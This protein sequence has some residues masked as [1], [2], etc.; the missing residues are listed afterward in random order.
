MDDTWFLSISAVEPT[1]IKLDSECNCNGV[2]ATTCVRAGSCLPQFA[3]F[4]GNSWGECEDD[5][6]GTGEGQLGC[7][8][9]EMFRNCADVAIVTNTAG[10][11]PIPE[12]RKQVDNI[13]I[14]NMQLPKDGFELV[15][16]ED[17]VDDNM[18]D[19]ILVY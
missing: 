11:P 16:D 2:E 9:Q 13:E 18:N 5:G 19:V 7:G 12:F 8:P 1:E 4:T 3:L 15:S 17:L 14:A 10:F 6:K